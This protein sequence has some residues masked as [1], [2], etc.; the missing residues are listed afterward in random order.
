MAVLPCSLV[1][2]S[3]AGPPFLLNHRPAVGPN[4]QHLAVGGV[5]RAQGQGLDSVF[6][7]V[8]AEK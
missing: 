2:Y 7:L 3:R 1:N 8:S 5:R 4:A 6:S